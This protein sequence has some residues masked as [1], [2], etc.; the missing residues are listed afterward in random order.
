M[1]SRHDLTE[2]R[3]EIAR[4]SRTLAGMGILD[5]FGHVSVRHPRNPNR[6][7]MARWQLA[8]RLVADDI[9]EFDIDSS[10]VYDNS[11]ELDPE[12]VID[13]C[14]YQMRPEVGA[15]CH[16][17]ANAIMPFCIA[18]VSPPTVPGQDLLSNPIPIWDSHAQFGDTGLWVTT[19]KE[20]I[21]LA[22]TLGSHMAILLARHG[23]TVVGYDLNDLTSRTI[24]MCANADALARTRTLQC[25]S[26]SG[27]DNLWMS[28]GPLA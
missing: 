27:P 10:P 19:A 12:R 5:P 9:I 23:A 26:G 16:H 3:H 2:L 14:I 7:L 8:A 11:L 20:A 21:S 1:P 4:V 17:H 15:V 28:R 25:V 18:G 22:E 13:G 24:Q 6:Y